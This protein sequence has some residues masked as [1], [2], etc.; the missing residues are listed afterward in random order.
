MRIDIPTQVRDILLR[1]QKAG[2]T[3]YAVGGCVRDSLLGKIPA[4]WDICTSAR[5]EQ[6]QTCFDR[7][8]L[9]GAK[10]GTVTVLRDGEGYEVTT[11]RTETG[12]ADSRHPDAVEFLDALEGDLARRDFTVNAMAADAEGRVTDLFGGLE[13][14]QSGILRCV[15]KPTER[16]SEDALR[17]L[18]ALRFASRF[19]FQI[20]AKTAEAIHSLRDT[21]TAVAAE[22]LHK[23]LSGLL[24]GKS[25]EAILREFS[26][27]LC[28]IIPEIAPCIGFL[29][30]NP[31]HK[32][33]VFEHTLCALTNTPQDEILRLAILLHDIGKPACFSLDDNGIGH[34]YGHAAESA[35][36][37]EQI[38]RRLHYDRRT[39]DLVTELVRAHDSYLQDL[40]DKGLRRLLA[41]YGEE[42]LRRL[43]LVR[44][45]D[46]LGTMTAD[47]DAL[48]T[49]LGHISHRIDAM[50]A[51]ESC[52]SVTD[53]AINGRDLMALG[54]P[55]G[56]Q[57]GTILK[58]LFDAVL[59]ERCPNDKAELVKFAQAL[60]NIQD[61]D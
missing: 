22:R 61:S 43:L 25:A 47:A 20:E 33:D 28:V 42:Q 8:L 45:A 46:A 23:E 1:L 12:Y 52:F 51:R 36:L 53:L 26:D 24:V 31:H 58:Q 32:L 21:L 60:Y 38:L 34:F 37:C 48:E 27:V 40:T 56:K 5:P 54:I 4:D 7:C 59:E 39:L 35:R 49:E 50:L 29:Q 55:Q 10:Y 14:L 2:H 18:R 13:D 44:R 57:L 16:F 11:Y 15:G 19:G 30:Q 17:I 6:T 3:A 9:T 41:T